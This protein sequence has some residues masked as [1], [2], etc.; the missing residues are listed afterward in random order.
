MKGIK[1][2]NLSLLLIIFNIGIFFNSLAWSLSRRSA[3]D[4]VYKLSSGQSLVIS[5]QTKNTNDP[6]LVY[7]PGSGPQINPITKSAV[8]GHILSSRRMNLL[9]INKV[10]VELDGKVRDAESFQ[11]GSV[12]NQRIIDNL[13]VMN[14]FIPKQSQIL[15][16]SL[17]EG[18]YIAPK[19]AL[20][21]ARVKSLILL[22]G[23]SW[24]WLEEE[25]QCAPAED[26]ESLRAY[27]EK[28]VLPNPVFDR[29]YQDWSF[30]YF[31][32]Y[33]TNDTYLELKKTDIPVLAIYGNRDK[34]IWLNGAIMNLK[35]LVSIENKSN[36]EF[37]IINGAGHT[38]KCPK[39]DSSCDSQKISSEI[40][41]LINP[42]VNSSF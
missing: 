28:E 23:N 33:A 29:F 26:Q 14:R 17:S 10:G 27:L 13:E 11:R 36:I 41:N 22:S 32:S 16:V 42:F 31:D 19:V 3:V 12:R 20:S 1:L 5:I 24:S 6:W 21:D 4:Q 15:L 35:K 7:L 39:E 37:H 40:N 25:V 8:L 18:A 9:I 34:T 30:A 2:K 38:L